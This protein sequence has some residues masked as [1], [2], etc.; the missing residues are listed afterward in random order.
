VQAARY[1]RENHIPYLGLC[2]GMQVM[3]VEAARSAL[4]SDMANSTEFDPETPNP[5]ISM[6]TEQQGI[7]EKGGTMRLGA[8]ACR[9]APGSGQA[10]YGVDEIRGRHRHRT[11]SASRRRE[12]AGGLHSPR[13]AVPDGTLVEVC[14]LRDHRS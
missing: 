13:V 5:V 4:G 8:Y 11:S 10:A 7:D 9:L 1:A 14:E 12:P 2:L 6:L 3:V